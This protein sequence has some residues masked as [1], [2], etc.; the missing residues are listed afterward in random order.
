MQ[1]P[2]ARR[3]LARSPSRLWTGE[4]R[5]HGRRAAG[6][7]RAGGRA[8]CAP[9][10]T[11]MRR[12]RIARSK[13]ARPRVSH[14]ALGQGGDG[15]SVWPAGVSLGKT[16]PTSDLALERFRRDTRRNAEP[17][18]DEEAFGTSQPSG[19]SADWGIVTLTV[20][21]ALWEG[22]GCFRRCQHLFSGIAPAARICL[23][24]P[25]CM[26][27]LPWQILSGTPC[28]AWAGWVEPTPLSDPL[29]GR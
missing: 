27:L 23:T 22:W 12:V 25:P 5:L 17:R 16:P 18:Q 28:L 24:C 6:A 2:G 26:I 1:R 11:G 29:P 3:T 4:P 15:S 9:P 14:R 13:A 10:Q 20:H 7:G 21:R 8:V 19:P